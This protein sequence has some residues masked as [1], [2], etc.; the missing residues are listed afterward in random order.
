LIT[1]LFR[2]PLPCDVDVER[3]VT[4]GGTA[5]VKH[6]EHEPVCAS[7]FVTVTATAPA[8]CADVVPLIVVDVI[9]PMVSAEPPNDTVA[10]D[11]KFAPLTVTDVPPAV[12]PLFGVTEVAVGAGGVTYV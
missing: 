4:L 12:E 2:P 5:Y 7:G 10:P 8:A 1:K 11:W 6:A 9:V 3:S